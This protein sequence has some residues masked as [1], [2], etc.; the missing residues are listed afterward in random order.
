M[1]RFILAVFTVVAMVC[2]PCSVGAQETAT[3]K[4]GHRVIFELTS[5]SPES[6]TGVL[7]NVENL[8]KSL[9]A[10]R[11]AC[12]CKSLNCLFD[13]SVSFKWRRIEPSESNWLYGSGAVRPRHQ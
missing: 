11:L 9:G 8:Q 3:A 5:D 12:S 7:N 13:S 6:W 10:A 1:N 2:S 4:E